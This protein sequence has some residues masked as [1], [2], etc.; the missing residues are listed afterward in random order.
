[1][2]W[3]TIGTVQITPT[4][5]QSLC[6]DQC[7]PRGEY[8]MEYTILTSIL[9]Y[10]FYHVTTFHPITSQYHSQKIIKLNIYEHTCITWFL[11][12]NT[13]EVAYYVLNV[14][15]LPWKVYDIICWYGCVKKSVCVNF[16]F[17]PCMILKSQGRSTRN[18]LT[19]AWSQ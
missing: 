1:M 9:R 16:A 3:T 15:Y 12:L 18:C 14:L 4:S 17:L 5:Q 2:L 19:L 7:W 11:L 10:I 6:I 8:T 13:Y